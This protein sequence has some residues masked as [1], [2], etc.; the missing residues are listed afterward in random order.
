M[1]IHKIPI[2]VSPLLFPRVSHYG[3]YFSVNYADVTIRWGLYESALRYVGWPIVPGFDVSGVVEAAGANSGFSPGDQVYGFSLFG[4]YSSRVLVPGRQLV[5]RPKALTA[6]QAAA[7]PAVAGT[8]LHA[9]HLAGFWPSPPLGR[10][11]AVLIHSAA[12]GVGSM[13]VQMAALCG[14]APIVAVVGQAHKAALCKA[15]GAHH[16]IDKSSEDLWARAGALCPE[17][18][19]AVF[20]ANGVSTL[21]KVPC[22]PPRSLSL[23]LSWILPPRCDEF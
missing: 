8:A 5:K 3:Q 17:G 15:L 10:N 9:L 2:F 20:D 21:A 11:R 18:F 6:E 22:L 12:G 7:V 14:C 16:V 13:L 1:F 23:T 4:A 19:A